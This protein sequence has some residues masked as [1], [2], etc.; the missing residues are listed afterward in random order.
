MT[1][2]DIADMAG[3][4]HLRQRIAAAAVTEGVTH[5]HPTVW[6]DA[7]QWYLA[8]SPGWSAAWQYAREVGTITELGRAEGVIDDGMI[9]S[10]VA[11]R[12]AEEEAARAEAEKSSPDPD[13]APRPEPGDPDWIEP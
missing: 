11:A 10:A 6:A 8:A 9:L 4:G 7:N 3:N 5:M 2:N 12:I 1:Y 13:A